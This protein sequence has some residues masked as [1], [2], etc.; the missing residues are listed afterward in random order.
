ME[1]PFKTLEDFGNCPTVAFR[2]P[3]KNG[4]KF[5]L[6]LTNFR[7]KS[8]CPNTGGVVLSM[9]DPFKGFYPEKA[10]EKDEVKENEE[11]EISIL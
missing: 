8:S 1:R 7:L 2:F 11:I 10:E 4:I 5:S 6:F 9:A 3:T